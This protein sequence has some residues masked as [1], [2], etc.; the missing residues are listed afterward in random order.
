M[1]GKEG[2]RQNRL[3]NNSRKATIK[4]KVLINFAIVSQS[5]AQSGAL[6]TMPAPGSWGLWK[7]QAFFFFFFK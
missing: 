3:S 1:P 5:M 2:K 4:H 6:L 7:C